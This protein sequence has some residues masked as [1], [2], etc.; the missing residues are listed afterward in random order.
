M[1]RA[2][3]WQAEGAQPVS[4]AAASLQMTA[5][6]LF[7][8]IPLR[9]L[10]LG[11]GSGIIAI[12][13]ALQKSAWHISGIDIQS[14]LIELA[15]ENA[16]R[17]GLAI[18]FIC[19][20]LRRF[21]PLD[22]YDLIV[23]NP[24]WLKLNAGIASPDIQREISRRELYCTLEDVLAFLQRSLR[25]GAEA[26]LLYPQSRFEEI[27][28]LCAHYLLDIIQALPSTDTNKYLIYHIKNKG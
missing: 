8:D 25:R 3:F 24:P 9:V 5:V 7:P 19:D 16:H 6:C 14:E 23:G 22:R 2:D 17:Q 27:E 20:D 28:S 18:N 15:S 21:T 4:S 11:C 26:L 12:M 10:D 1:G 13:L